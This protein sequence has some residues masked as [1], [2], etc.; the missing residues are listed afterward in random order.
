MHKTDDYY[1]VLCTLCSKTLEQKAVVVGLKSAPTSSGL[2]NASLGVFSLA[3]DHYDLNSYVP[4]EHPWVYFEIGRFPPRLRWFLG[5]L[6]RMG[7][8]FAFIGHE[9]VV[10]LI[11]WSIFMVAKRLGFM[12]PSMASTWI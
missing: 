8:V 10:F 3:I 11:E 4:M 5:E 9:I 6:R 2:K 7:L 12:G 1:L